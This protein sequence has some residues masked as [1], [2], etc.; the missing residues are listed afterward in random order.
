MFCKLSLD[1]GETY[2]KTPKYFWMNIRIAVSIYRKGQFK[3]ESAA[4]MRWDSIGRYKGKVGMCLYLKTSL[5]MTK[6]IFSS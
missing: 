5:L 1:T 4:K 2:N 6:L 3:G